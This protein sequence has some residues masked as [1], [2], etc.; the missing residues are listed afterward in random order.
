MTPH[1]FF[2]RT[3]VIPLTKYFCRKGY[4]TRIGTVATKTWAAFS[5][6]LE[7]VI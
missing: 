3:D 7:T 6:S 4:A 2:N 1:L 5:V